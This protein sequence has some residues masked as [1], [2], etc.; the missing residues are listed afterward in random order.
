MIGRVA[1]IRLES[2]ALQAR[3]L[4]KAHG[5]EYQRAV[6]M[7]AVEQ[8]HISL[9]GLDSW[10]AQQCQALVELRVQPEPISLVACG[11]ASAV[12]SEAALPG[13]LELTR[14]QVEK[15]RAAVLGLV[16]RQVLLIGFKMKFCQ[17]D[18]AMERR[19]WDVLASAQLS[20][21]VESAELAVQQVAD[22]LGL[23]PSL[24]Q[25]Q[26]L[27]RMAAN[28]VSAADAVHALVARRV[29]HGLLRAA[30]QQQP[31]SQGW[32]KAQGLD[33]AAEV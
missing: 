31:L 32:A 26:Y 5:N 12:S 13:L 8:G 24:E 2:A 33:Y 19:A 4:L 17:R 15:L 29:G 16:Q 18:S 22:E 7:S 28:S 27:D 3:V 14:T 30:V 25:Q 21:S 9:D 23:Q 1:A 6:A 11:L 20:A 10:A